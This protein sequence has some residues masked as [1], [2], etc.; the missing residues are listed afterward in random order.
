TKKRKC[1]I[2]STN[3]KNNNNQATLSTLISSLPENKRNAQNTTSHA[4]VSLPHGIDAQFINYF[5]ISSTVGR[6]VNAPNLAKQ[7]HASS[8][9]NIIS[10]SN[11]NAQRVG[12]TSQ[13]ASNIDRIGAINQ[14]KISKYD[15]VFIKIVLPKLDDIS[16]APHQ[17]LALHQ[18]CSFYLSYRMNDVLAK[19]FSKSMFLKMLENYCSHLVMPKFQSIPRLFGV[20]DISK[21]ASNSDMFSYFS[22]ISVMNNLANASSGTSSFISTINIL[23]IPTSTQSG[24]ISITNFANITEDDNN[25]PP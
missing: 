22:D 2:S 10:A 23:N 20:S 16:T 4:T 7:S 5:V 1:E 6:N 25:P 9:S 14:M 17:L 11:A 18:D 15:L 3:D 13:Y 8:S 19:P 21:S 12:N 24:Q